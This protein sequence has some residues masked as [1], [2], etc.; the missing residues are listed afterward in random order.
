MFTFS[1]ALGSEA[2]QKW[3]AI[4]SKR[5]SRE[6]KSRCIRQTCHRAARIDYLFNTECL[7]H[8]LIAGIFLVTDGVIV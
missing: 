4:T 8:K 7:F 6:V 5:E 2:A 3:P 1:R